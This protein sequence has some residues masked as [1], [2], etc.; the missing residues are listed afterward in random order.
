M[1][2]AT[3][4][5]QDA[6]RNHLQLANLRDAYDQLLAA[7]RLRP[8]FDNSNSRV[9]VVSLHHD[10]CIPYK[11]ALYKWALILEINEPAYET[12]A[13]LGDA[14]HGHFWPRF[15]KPQADEDDNS[16]ADDEGLDD[17][18]PGLRIVSASD[19]ADIIDFSRHTDYALAH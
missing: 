10:D 15:V 6:F 17:A 8:K 7:T 19:I 1:T 11:L 4:D 5:L 9:K 18:L 13:R 16:Q 3:A 2:E 14:P 12:W